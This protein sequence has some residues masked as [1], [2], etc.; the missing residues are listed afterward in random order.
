MGQGSDADQ[1]HHRQRSDPAGAGRPLVDVRDGARSGRRCRRRDGSRLL[2][3]Q[4]ASLVCPGFPWALDA[5]RAQ[6]GPHRYRLGAAGGTHRRAGRRPD[7]PGPGL[8]P[9]LWRGPGARTDRPPRRRGVMRRPWRRSCGRARSFPVRV[10][11]PSTA[12]RPSNSSTARPAPPVGAGGDSPAQ[13]VLVRP[14]AGPRG[15]A[16]AVRSRWRACR[17]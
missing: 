7:P 14:I 4:P 16:K 15:L 9:G 17:P 2:P 13:T 10:S 12:L 6:P 3:R 11:T 5:A 1:R 8:P